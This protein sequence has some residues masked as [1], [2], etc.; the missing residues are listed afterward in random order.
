MKPKDLGAKA[1]LENGQT[2]CSRRN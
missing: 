1:T 2:L